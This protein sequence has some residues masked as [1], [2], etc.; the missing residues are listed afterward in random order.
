[1]KVRIVLLLIMVA[2]QP[3]LAGS[4][5][6]PDIPPISSSQ[7][8]HPGKFVWGD[9]VTDDVAAA[10]AFYSGLLGWEFQTLNRPRG[11][12]LIGFNNGRP[13]GGVL[14]A[15]PKQAAKGQPRWIG[16]ISVTDLT[17][18][19]QSVALAGGKVLLAP[20]SLPGR[21]E[22][23]IFSDPEGAVFG[24][25]K[26]ATGDPEDYLANP[27]DWIWVQLLSRDAAKAGE[28]YRSVAGYDVI[29][30]ETNAGHNSLV[31]A[32][33]GY[34][35]ATIMDIPRDRPS[36]QPAWL[37]FV[38][39]DTLSQSLTRTTVLG[40]RVLLAPRPDLLEGHLAVVADPTGS[41]IGLIEWPQSDAEGGK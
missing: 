9:L 2:S 39:V 31:L 33:D 1:M 8:W 16:Y 30:D 4:S 25:I 15:P 40:G 6:N 32:A 7:Q 21:G 27:G 23:A 13:V 12:Y 11:S 28:F 19:M 22:Q 36:L 20:K 34:A 17:Q 35:R 3:L 38:R 26:T 29:A 10:K 5:D 14:E 24:L 18:A 41:A 37:P